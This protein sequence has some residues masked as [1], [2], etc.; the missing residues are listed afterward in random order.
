MLGGM[1][2]DR[3]LSLLLLLQHRGRC[4]AAEL[5]D[6]LEVSPRT[7]LRDVEALSAAG[8]PVYAERGRHGGFALLPGYSTDL[9]G[10]TND[11][12]LALLVAGSRGRRGGHGA[13]AGVGDAQG[14]GGP[15]R[16][17]T[18]GRGPRRG[19]DPRA[20][21][22]LAAASRH[23]ETGRRGAARHRA[24]RRVRRTSAGPP[25]RRARQGAAVAH[26]RPGRAGDRGRTLVPARAAR[27]RGAHLPDGE[28]AGGAGARRARGAAAG[29]RS[30]RGVAG[31]PDGVRRVAA[32]DRGGGAGARERRAD[33]VRTVRAVIAET[34]DADG[35]LRF[36]S[37]SATRSTPSGCSG[38]SAPTSRCSPPRSSAATLAAASPRSPRA[39]GSRPQ[40]RSRR[41]RRGGPARPDRAPHLATSHLT[42]EV[43]GHPKGCEVGR[44]TAQVRA[45]CEVEERR[46][47]GTRIGCRP[48]GT[49]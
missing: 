17:A 1:R 11:E 36:T 13:R 14:R 23:A 5:A 49:C 16:G 18:G 3:L 22:G 32:G 45:G 6:E 28:G 4:S 33:L 15:A 30:R 10:L 20:R 46:G 34:G 29:G 27:R 12:A 40:P 44:A 38:R 48:H 19:S 42:G 7:V 47:G 2:A 21:R 26:G 39:M 9:T 8:V 24:G 41:G 25:L 43:F 31:A 37:S 35:E